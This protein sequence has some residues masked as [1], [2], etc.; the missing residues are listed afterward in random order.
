MAPT[1][2]ISLLAIAAIA[3]G[4]A[5]FVAVGPADAAIGIVRWSAVG[6]DPTATINYRLNLPAN[7][8]TIQIKKASDNSVVKTITLGAGELADGPHSV[9]W[10]GTTDGGGAAPTG[11]YYATITVNRAAVPSSPDYG[12]A[13]RIRDHSIQEP[14]AHRYFGVDADNNPA[15]NNQVDPS[16]STFGNIYLAN[17]VSKNI[18]VWLP[19]NPDAADYAA[20]VIGNPDVLP[21]WGTGFTGGSS[22]W[23]LGVS[24]SGRVFSMDRS[25][26]TARANWNWDGS[27]RK[28]NANSSVMGYTRDNDVV[29]L[30]PTD[31]GDG[32]YQVTV[33]DG[34]KL[35]VAKMG[36]DYAPPAGYSEPK[37]L[38]STVAPPDSWPTSNTPNGICV[39]DESAT[40]MNTIWYIANASG[41]VKRWT[42]LGTGWADI[43]LSQDTGFNL[44][45]PGASDIS[46]S[47]KN[48]NI[49][50]VTRGVV[51]AGEKNIQVW[52]IS[53]QTKIGEY[54]IGSSATSKVAFDA[55]GNALV[56]SGSYIQGV[57]AYLYEIR[58]TPSRSPTRVGIRRRWWRAQSQTRTPSRRMMPQRQS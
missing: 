58:A 47:P 49:A 15:N 10:D 7:S 3:A 1:R 4:V 20:C 48:P 8:G 52:D 35:V 19:G 33:S 55:W 26:N 34:P 17:T 14:T 54:G 22:P 24:R 40:L 18:E 38:T 56:V 37:S 32:V 44:A 6:S 57:W 46:I 25:G 23:G 27:D 39:G 16:K 2:L 29:G 51:G 41:W 50:V 53:T 11:S 42:T 43:S 45:V 9:V 28:G 31:T 5:A 21:G 13:F 30:D 12:R 36:A